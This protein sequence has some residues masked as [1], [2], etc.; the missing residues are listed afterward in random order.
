MGRQSPSVRYAL[1]AALSASVAFVAWRIFRH[2][3]I[4]VDATEIDLQFTPASPHLLDN[5]VFAGETPPQLIREG[6]GALFH[7]RYYV[8]IAKATTTKE[9]L[10]DRITHN[11]NEVAPS[12]I[13]IFQK[14]TTEHDDMQVGD[15]YFIH[16]ASPWNGPVRVIDVTPTSFSFITLAG[17]FEAGE[18][19]FRLIDHPDDPTLMRFEIRSWSRSADRLVNFL[20][21]QLTIIKNAQTRMWVYFCQQVAEVSGGEVVGKVSVVTQRVPYRQFEQSLPKDVQRWQQYKPRIEYMRRAKLN[22]D[23]DKREEFIEANGWRHDKYAIDLP[24]E[25][26]GEPEPNGAFEQAKRVLLNYEFPDPSLISG[27]FI[28]DDPLDQRVML[29][30]AKFLLFTFYFG[31]QIGSV[32]DEVREDDQKGRAHV[33]G[34]SYRTLQGHFEMGEI[35]FEIW[36]FLTTGE[37]EFRIH[38]YSKTDVIR[39]PF[40]RL[41]FALFGRRLQRRFAAT[42]L[43]RMQEIVANRLS[44]VAQPLETPDIKTTSKQEIEDKS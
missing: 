35:T 18:I 40:Y 33:W 24:A 26:G 28:P 22:F 32:I 1:L 44:G 9:A 27:I 13:A 6:R 17:H 29:L 7:R 2:A 34:Y 11:L 21:D 3:R 16:I 31:V 37:I 23:L 42:A 19:Q 20:Y 43:T 39:N 38:A 15:D 5:R 41:G 8:D 36:K 30:E 10:M 14:M 4:P 12:E 25:Q